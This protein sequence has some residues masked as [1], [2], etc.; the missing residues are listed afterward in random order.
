VFLLHVLI[1]ENLPL[2]IFLVYLDIIKHDIPKWL[3][4]MLEIA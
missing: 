3:S 4:F 2:K 1:A